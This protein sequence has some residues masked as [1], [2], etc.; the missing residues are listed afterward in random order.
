MKVSAKCLLQKLISGDDY[1]RICSCCYEWDIIISSK[2]AVLQACFFMFCWPCISKCACNETNLMHYLSSVDWV[3][4]TLHV[5]GLLVAHYQEVAMY[6]CDNWYVLYVVVD[7]RRAADRLISLHI[8]SK[9][10][11]FHYKD[12]IIFTRKQC[13]LKRAY[14]IILN[15]ILYLLTYF[16]F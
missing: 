9:L 6:I 11:L 4:T 10:M 3:T 8:Y 16:I 12:A 1:C 14:N 13:F 15:Y 5:S 7:C 2:Q